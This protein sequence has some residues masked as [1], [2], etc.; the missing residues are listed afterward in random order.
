MLDDELPICTVLVKIAL[1]R[2]A[3]GLVVVVTPKNSRVRNTADRPASAVSIRYRAIRSQES[4]EI[5]GLVSGYTCSLSVES[6][7]GHAKDSLRGIDELRYGGS[8]VA[9]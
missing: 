3:V 1:Q 4:T 8:P 2:R 9:R 6:H 7:I 5:L